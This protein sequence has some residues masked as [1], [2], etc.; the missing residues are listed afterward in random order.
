MSVPADR[1]L[2][3]E[4]PLP[5]S[6]SAGLVDIVLVIADTPSLSR[7]ERDRRDVELINRCADELNREAKEVF[8]YQEYGWKRYGGP[9]DH[10]EG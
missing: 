7:A 2:R 6:V 4:V 3:L 10:E 8:S 5:E 1:C 9:F